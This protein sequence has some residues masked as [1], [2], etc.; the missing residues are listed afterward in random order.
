MKQDINSIANRIIDEFNKHGCTSFILTKE[1]LK[2]L[3]KEKY[4]MT[5]NNT[6]VK[7]HFEVCQMLNDT[8]KKKNHDYGNSFGKTF[9]DWG[10]S[11][12]GVRIEDKFNRFK[13][14]AQGKETLVNDETIADTLLDMA[15][16]CIM[17]YMELSN[18]KTDE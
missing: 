10:I 13:S 16:Y 15:N 8:Y 17:T 7:K 18:T 3:E 2:Q 12:A 14:L 4:I 5:D 6:L 1:Q 9:Q 11:S